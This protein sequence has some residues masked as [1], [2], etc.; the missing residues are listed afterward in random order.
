VG[1]NLIFEPTRSSYP[2]WAIIL[3][4]GETMGS[5]PCPILNNLSKFQCCSASMNQHPL[6]HQLS[7]LYTT[8][9]GIS[10]RD[11]SFNTWIYINHNSFFFGT[12]HYLGF[13]FV[14]IVFP[15]FHLTYLNTYYQPFWHYLPTK[16]NPPHLYAYHLTTHPPLHAYV[17]YIL[18]TYPLSLLLIINNNP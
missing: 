12:D 10:R 7:V 16:F 8:W 13:F 4:V 15:N 9:E 5:W 17:I 11:F 1:F 18:P 2:A 3:K 14:L 6:V